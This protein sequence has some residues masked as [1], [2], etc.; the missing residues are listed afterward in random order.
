MSDL[1]KRLRVLSG[2]AAVAVLAAAPAFA[3]EVPIGN[4]IEKN[5]MNVAAVYLQSVMMAPMLPGMDK[6]SDVHLEADIHA[7]RGNENGFRDEEWIPYLTITYPL[8][9][10]GSTW[11]T[12]GAFMPMCADDGPHYGDNVKLDGPGKYHLTYDILPP[13]YNGFYHHVDKETGTKEWWEPF[14]VAWDFTYAGV[15]KKGGY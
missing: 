8:E 1:T 15:G 9:K 13:A 3:A 5:G 12:T 4:P 11:K 6:P 14:Q 10:E 2:A 7:L